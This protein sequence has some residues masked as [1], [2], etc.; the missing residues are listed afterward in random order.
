M[1]ILAGRICRQEGQGVEKRSFE[2][3][4]GFKIWMM[5]A[6]NVLRAAVPSASHS[7]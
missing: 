6:A 4:S 3:T 5:A 1:E 7:S 2:A